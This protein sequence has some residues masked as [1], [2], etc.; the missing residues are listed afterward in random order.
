MVLSNG[1]LRPRLVAIVVAAI[2]AAAA[3]CGPTVPVGGS[4]TATNVVVTS[5]GIRECPHTWEWEVPRYLES[6]VM[7]EEQLKKLTRGAH[8]VPEYND[9][10]KFVIKESGQVVYSAGQFA[11]FAVQDSDAL[12]SLNDGGRVAVAVIFAEQAYA[13][14]GIGRGFNCLVL[15]A[16]GERRS[17]WMYRP[18]SKLGIADC[19]GEFPSRGGHLL[20]VKPP[21]SPLPPD[22]GH[23]AKLARWGYDIDREVHYMTVTCGEA[24]CHVGPQTG[25]FLVASLPE[26]TTPPA[27]ALKQRVHEVATWYDEQLLAELPAG[28]GGLQPSDVWGTVIPHHD[29]GN[30]NELDDF[31]NGWVTVAEVRLSA[32][33]VDYA[34]KGFQM[35]RSG[36][37]NLV[38]SCV[39]EETTNARGDVTLSTC[40]GLPPAFLPGGGECD[41]SDDPS[42]GERWRSRH[43][44]VDGTIKY[45]CVKRYPLRVEGLEVPAAARWRWRAD[46]EL[47]WYRCMRGCCDEQV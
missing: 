32:D 16:S 21:V 39:I 27:N 2:G 35:T 31:K 43:T 26:L 15:H 13:P 42:T 46:D 14:L 34:A 10:Q 29:L 38:E 36:E 6:Q 1:K 12:A 45:F 33:H 37:R 19:S 8:H 17:A 41:A 7:I 47:L 9:C 28:V 20:T 40:P 5:E 18:N 30:L 23:Y 3:G 11:I 4:G 22:Q 24:V 44:A 25:G